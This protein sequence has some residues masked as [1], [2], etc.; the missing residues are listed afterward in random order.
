MWSFSIYDKKKGI[1][2]ISRDRF[3]EKPLYYFHEKNF[4]C[5][6]SEVK[7][8]LKFLNIYPNINYEKIKKFLV[9]GFRTLFKDRESFFSNIKEL[10]PS[11]NLVLN[12]KNEI[13]INKYWKIN[14]SSVKIPESEIY[15]E[16]KRLLNRSMLLRMRADVPV[17][18]CLSGGIDSSSLAAIATKNLKKNIHT[19]S[20]IDKDARYD[21]SAN[22][23]KVVNHLKCESSFIETSSENFL[24]NLEKIISY[25]QSPV[26]T[27]S[28]YIHNQLIKKIKESGFSVA[29]SGTGADEIF[30]GY[31][32]HYN[33]WLQMMT[34]EPNFEKLRDEWKKG[35]GRK[36][37][38]PLIKNITQF[39]ENQNYREHL[40]QNS[41]DFNKILIDKIDVKFE[42]IKYSSDNLRNRMI[43][44][45]NHE[46][47]PTILYSDDLNS[48]MHSIENRSPF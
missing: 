3:G 41:K 20:V 7:F 16:T 48:M 37:N 22:I 19:F 14:Y 26:P 23:S 45:L 30:T 27:V 47:V 29:I 17:A 35:Y 15:Q 5:F 21:E 32:D 9:C 28:Y 8:I 25:Y 39:I 11:C 4:F 18:F 40:Y 43:N 34:S 44:E 12:T 36:V 1:I 24:T 38:N 6:G 33:F 42:E 2:F 10:E 13:E 46:I 31:Y